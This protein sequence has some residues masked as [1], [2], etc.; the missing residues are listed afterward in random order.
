ML[1]EA[2]NRRI[3]LLPSA[4]VACHALRTLLELIDAVVR[5]PAVSM[6]QAEHPIPNEAGGAHASADAMAL[7]GANGTVFAA[8]AAALERSSRRGTGADDH[9]PGETASTP[10]ACIPREGGAP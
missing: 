1:D 4:H 5:T 3:R 8:G 9:A 10:L 2:A 6:I 7:E